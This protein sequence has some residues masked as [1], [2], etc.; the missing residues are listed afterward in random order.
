[1]PQLQ[2]A[3][4]LKL[5]PLQR[6]LSPFERTSLFFFFWTNGPTSLV[7]I[8]AN[9]R[10]MQTNNYLTD[11]T[12][13]KR[14][15]QDDI[16]NKEQEI[17]ILRNRVTELEKEVESLR[18]GQILS[19]PSQD[20]NRH[21]D[22]LLG[23]ALKIEWDSKRLLIDKEL[24]TLALS[25]NF[26]RPLHIGTWSLYLIGH[27]GELLNNSFKVVGV[28]KEK[29]FFE[30]NGEEIVFFYD[31]PHALQSTSRLDRYRPSVRSRIKFRYQFIAFGAVGNFKQPF[32][33]TAEQISRLL[34][35]NSLRRLWRFGPI[36]DSNI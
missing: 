28:S 14:K 6:N 31:S 17:E 32:S 30:V 16:I 12:P 7:N 8:W 15:Y 26:C 19:I 36:K 24:K 4:S 2:C 20:G 1:M 35:I 13:R 23:T 3:I 27:L 10:Q 9:S 29:T 34:N 21:I 22:E 11:G 18:E 5:R 33:A 25:V